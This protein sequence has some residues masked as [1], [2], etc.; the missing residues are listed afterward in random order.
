ME[1]K[2]SSIRIE[3]KSKSTLP[4]G[5]KI[6]SRSL[7][8][9]VRQIENGYVLRKSYDIKYS[10]GDKID[11]M[12]YTTEVYSEENPVEIKKSSMLADIFK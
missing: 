8:A 12:Y 1:D 11:Y 10:I 6:L 7:D 4:K 3:E 2:V 5:A 9:S